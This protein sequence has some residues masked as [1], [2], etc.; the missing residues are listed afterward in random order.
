MSCPRLMYTESYRRGAAGEESGAEF[1]LVLGP[2]Y[3]HFAMDD[4]AIVAYFGE[5]RHCP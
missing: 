5:L 3:L 4:K 1:A 2:S